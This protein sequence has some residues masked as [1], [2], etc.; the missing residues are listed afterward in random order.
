MSDA[1]EGFGWWEASDGKWYPPRA[2]EPVRGLLGRFWHGLTGW[3]QVGGVLLLVLLALLVGRIGPT[4]TGST[5]ATVLYEVTGSAKYA[6][7]TY[8]T[9]NG[10]SAQQTDVDVP[11]KRKS[12]EAGLTYTMRQGQFFY[13]SAQNGTESGSI[14]CTVKVNGKVVKANTSFGGYSIVTCSGTV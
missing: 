11:L 3:Q 10:D 13:I 4:S 7:I 8:Q 9:G 14:I 12:G 1:P 6:S 5:T 2:A